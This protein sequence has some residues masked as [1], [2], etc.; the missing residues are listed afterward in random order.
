MKFILLRERDIVFV[1]WR[2]LLPLCPTSSP[3]PPSLTGLYTLSSG[4]QDYCSLNCGQFS[5]KYSAPS[6]NPLAF[7]SVIRGLKRF[8]PENLR[9]VASTPTFH[10]VWLRQYQETIL[11]RITVRGIEQKPGQ[12]GRC[13]PHCWSRVSPV[14][15]TKSSARTVRYTPDL[16]YST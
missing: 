5:T 2:F 11:N 8:E 4:F 13:R 7:Y 15:N 12:E 6:T 9:R 1:S 14:A 16:Q 10:R 3:P